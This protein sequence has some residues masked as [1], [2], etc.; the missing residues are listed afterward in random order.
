MIGEEELIKEPCGSPG[1]LA[2]E[3]LT[4]KGWGRPVDMFSLGVITYILLCGVPPFHD[5]QHR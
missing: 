4:G 1:Y 3:V 5:D 2:P